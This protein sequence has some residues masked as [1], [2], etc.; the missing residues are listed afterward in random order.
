[1]KGGVAGVTL[2]ANL[3]MHNWVIGV[4]ADWD[5][6]GMAGSTGCFPGAMPVTATCTAK[7]NWIATAR[8]RL[9][10]AIDR[11]LP[12]ITAGAA[13]DALDMNAP[14]VGSFNFSRQ[15]WVVGGGLEFNVMGPLTAKLEYLHL[16][17]GSFI[18]NCAAV[19]FPP[20]PFKA[21]TTD[22]VRIG[23]NYKFGG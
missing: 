1:M 18:C 3:Q 11:V 6:S 7:I 2:G 19:G 13:F 15:G 8:G 12:Y 20:V 23:L 9:G 5:W 10:Y 14:T 4:E 17:F 22:L 16:D 21:S